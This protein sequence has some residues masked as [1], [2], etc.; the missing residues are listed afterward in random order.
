MKETVTRRWEVR[1]GDRD[2][3]WQQLHRKKQ[4]SVC[5]GCFGN[6]ELLRGAYKMGKFAG[7]VVSLVCLNGQSLISGIGQLGR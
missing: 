4:L 1:L 5:C 7:L 3:G 6:L 2:W